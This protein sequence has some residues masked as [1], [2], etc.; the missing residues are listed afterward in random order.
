MSV[1]AD[2]VAPIAH[3]DKLYIGGRWVAPTT[4]KKLQLVSPIDDEQFFEVA[5]AGAGDLEAAVS[6]ARKAF[7]HGLWPRMPPPE[8]AKLMRKLGKSLDARAVALERA[9][10]AQIGTPV[11]M[12]TGSVGAVVALLNYYADLADKFKFEDARKSGG[13]V[14]QVAVVTREPV[15]VVAAIAPWNGPL[16]TMMMK[17]APALAAGCVVIV[18][19][20]PE[21][22]IETF[23]LAEAAEEAGLPDGVLNLLP[24]GREI[25]DQLVRHPGVDKVAFTGST[26]VGMQIAAICASR[27][28]RY[29]MELGGKSAAIVLEDFDPARIGPMLAPVITMGCGQ[30]YPASA[31]ATMSRVWLS[32]WVKRKSATRWIKQPGWARWRCAVN[33]IKCWGISTRAKRKAP[34][35]PPA[36]GDPRVSTAAAI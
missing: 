20:S 18:K 14:S 25:S 1:I 29:T 3:A 6:A 15:G 10:I 32:P 26:A 5:E 30:A 34:R 33:L 24:A 7:D 35:L 13:Y 9:W 16:M 19:P 27:M 28:A 11:A 23:L 22:P 17:L 8:R 36:E 21:T 4:K 2:F 12:A 31:M